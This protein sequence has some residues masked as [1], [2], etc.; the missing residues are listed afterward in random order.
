MSGVA[1]WLA[2]CTDLELIKIA[3]NPDESAIRR[4]AADRELARRKSA[5]TTET[6]YREGEA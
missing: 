5:D 2:I 4:R 3:I 6:T 1:N